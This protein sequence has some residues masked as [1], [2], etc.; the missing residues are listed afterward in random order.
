MLIVKTKSELTNVATQDYVYVQRSKKIYHMQDG[1]WIEKVY[2]TVPE[3]AEI[4]GVPVGRVKYN[5]KRKQMYVKNGRRGK[6]I[7]ITLKQ[8]RQILS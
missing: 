5:V 4:L 7:L 3:C 1:E 2:F 6:S 8:L